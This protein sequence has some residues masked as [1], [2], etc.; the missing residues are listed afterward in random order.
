MPDVPG[1]REQ[2]ARSP[3]AGETGPFISFSAVRQNSPQG[4]GETVPPAGPSLARGL[5]AFLANLRH[6]LDELVVQVVGRARDDL[7]ADQIEWRALQPEL[8]AE[9]LGLVERLL[10]GGILHILFQ[11]RNVEAEF[12]GDLE[13]LVLVGLAGLGEQLLVHLE[14]F[15]LL[16]GG[17]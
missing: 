3:R 5:A 16:A 17:E 13:R 12:T 4:R 2:P 7:I 15:A 1:A 8:L 14:I 11:L 9:V 6:V 10:D